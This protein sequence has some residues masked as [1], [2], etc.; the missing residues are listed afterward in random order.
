MILIVYSRLYT[1]TILSLYILE[2]A[3]TFTVGRV[4]N[5]VIFRV[6]VTWSSTSYSIMLVANSSFELMDGVKYLYGTAG[7]RM[8]YYLHPY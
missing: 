8:K 6:G 5:W 1:F 4:P 2:F 7:F 3:R